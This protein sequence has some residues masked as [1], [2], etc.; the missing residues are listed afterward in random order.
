VAD[1]LL[2]G[3][4]PL[5][6]IISARS[7]VPFATVLSDMRDWDQV[8]T[9]TPDT[10]PKGCMSEETAAVTG[11]SQV[12]Q[13]QSWRL[14]FHLLGRRLSGCDGGAIILAALGVENHVRIWNQPVPGSTAGGAW[15]VAASLEKGCLIRAA[16]RRLPHLWHCIQPNGYNEPV[17]ALTASHTAATSRS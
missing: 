10:M 7:T 1:S 17:L 13:G 9:G 6:V 5:N 4:E 14:S 3:K 16:D 2:Q 8:T 12:G 11:T 15:F